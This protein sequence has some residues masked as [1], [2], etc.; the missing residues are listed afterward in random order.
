MPRAL[1]A[2]A[3]VFMRVPCAMLYYATIAT[4]MLCYY[5]RHAMPGYAADTPLRF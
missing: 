5:C 2:R 3:R 4:R 1:S